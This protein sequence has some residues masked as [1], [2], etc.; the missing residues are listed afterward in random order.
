MSSE[1]KGH[2]PL[3]GCCRH[4]RRTL[5]SWRQAWDHEAPE[6]YAERVAAI[7]RQCPRCDDR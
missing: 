7:R 2:G 5:T 6:E 1:P 4:H 3:A